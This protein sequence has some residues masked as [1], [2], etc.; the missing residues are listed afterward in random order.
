MTSREKEINS[1]DRSIFR[2]VTLYSLLYSL[3]TCRFLVMTRIDLV[4]NA[5]QSP[6]WSTARNVTLQNSDFPFS[7]V[8][9]KHIL[10]NSLELD[11]MVHVSPNIG[12]KLSYWV[13][14]FSMQGPEPWPSFMICSQKMWNIFVQSKINKIINHRLYSPQRN[15]HLPIHFHYQ[16]VKKPLK[17]CHQ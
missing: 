12:T 2:L 1:V 5:K 10:L 14:C 6:R 13:V 11:Y 17:Y 9:F 3:I 8:E 4:R 7:F 15:V 16:V